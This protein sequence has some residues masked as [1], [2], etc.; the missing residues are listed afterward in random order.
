MVQSDRVNNGVVQ[1]LSLTAAN[2]NQIFLS[3][4]GGCGYA[5]EFYQCWTYSDCIFLTDKSETGPG[6]ERYR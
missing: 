6:A 4:H 2:A 5:G 1:S 3:H